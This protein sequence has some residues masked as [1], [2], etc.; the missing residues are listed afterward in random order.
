M[1]F[2]FRH[3]CYGEEWQS[4]TED[5]NLRRAFCHQSVAEEVAEEH[6]QQDPS[7]PSDFSLDVWVRDEK[8]VVKRFN[9]TAEARVE[10]MAGEIENVRPA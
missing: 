7:D 5:G 2:E 9:V 8:G 1:G 10:F 4:F 6:W 3:K